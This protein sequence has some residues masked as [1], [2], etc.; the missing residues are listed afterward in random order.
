MTTQEAAGPKTL[1]PQPQN[2][3][4]SSEVVFVE[5]SGWLNI[6]AHLSRS[7][8]IQVCPVLQEKALQKRKSQEELL[9]MY[10]P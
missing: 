8:L 4:D 10:L 5:S 6:A 2:F 3:Q 9:C 7:S 1:P